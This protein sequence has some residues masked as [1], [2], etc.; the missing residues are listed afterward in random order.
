ME[1][2][3]YYFDEQ[4]SRIIKLEWTSDFG[5]LNIFDNDKLIH[6]HS[7]TKQLKKGILLKTSKGENL[8]IRLHPS[9]TR[10]EVSFGDQFALN[11]YN[12]SEDVV[13]G[14]SQIFY[15]VFLASTTFFMVQFLPQYRAGLI[16]WEALLEPEKLI[17]IGLIAIF[18]IAGIMVKKG[19]IF[20]YY[21]GTAL[22]LIDTVYVF[23][24]T[25]VIADLR[26]ELLLKSNIG[27]ILF[28]L[29]MIRLVFAFYLIKAFKYSVA[30]YKHLKEWAK[31]K[32][33]ELLDV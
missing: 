12:R 31:N 7:N 32:D 13:K 24:Y 17:Y 19:N 16:G 25:F 18:Y 27:L 5:K 8:Y 15:Y 23:L 28:G 26:F 14:T 1:T 21:L 22:Y 2:A 10:W 6:Q 33:G 3:N 4:K 9:P 20:W 29:L 11:S 30:Y